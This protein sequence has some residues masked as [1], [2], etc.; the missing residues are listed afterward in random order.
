MRTTIKI[1]DYLLERAKK[2]A[3]ENHITVSDIIGEALREKLLRMNENSQKNPV[4]IIT[5][6]GNGLQ[7]GVDL[8]DMASL[9]D[10]ME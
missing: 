4:K 2:I 10:L 3:L 7:P 5:F 6:K 8:D 1:D 9:L